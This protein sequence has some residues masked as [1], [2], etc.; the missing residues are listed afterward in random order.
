MLLY[1]C[2]CNLF[3]SQKC[4][5]STKVFHCIFIISF[6]LVLGKFLRFMCSL[7]F[8]Q[9]NRLRYIS[10]YYSYIYAEK[11]IWCSFN[12]ISNGRFYSNLILN[13]KTPL[14][15]SQEFFDIII[16]LLVLFSTVLRHTIQSN[17]HT[18]THTRDYKV[19]NIQL[20][21]T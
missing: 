13:I 12:L 10:M 20:F 5:H 2:M 14:F 16:K 21:L 3:V 6:V 19:A 15:W 11:L 8:H 7:G 9:Y 17:T 4:N 18:H 1:V